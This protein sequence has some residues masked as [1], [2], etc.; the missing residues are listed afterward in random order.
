MP[1]KKARR[2]VVDASVAGAAG[3]ETATAPT[4]TRCRDFLKTLREE[5]RCRV[6]MPPK[7]KGEW[8]EHQSKFARRWLTAMTSSGRV[9]FDDVPASS[10]MRREIERAAAANQREAAALRK[11]FHLV[12]AA[13]GSDRNVVSLDETVRRLF[14]AAARSVAA[15]KK[16][17]WVN[18]ANTS[19]QPVKWL[20][21][22]V[23]A[24]TVRMLGYRERER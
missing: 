21:D 13:L 19:E 9:I 3:M 6:V 11:D 8:D 14:K 15:I 24:E 17:V 1:A 16:V 23:K 4:S 10:R 5:T 22:G 18:P 20:R 2:L 12:E 7:L